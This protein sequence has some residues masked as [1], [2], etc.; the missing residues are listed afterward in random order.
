MFK[1]VVE[2]QCKETTWY[3]PFGEKMVKIGPV[4]TV[5]ALLIVK[6]KN[7]LEMRDKA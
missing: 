1:F 7:K 5:I 3:L 2:R 4:G 6:N